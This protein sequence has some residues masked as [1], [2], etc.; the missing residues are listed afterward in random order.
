MFPSFTGSS[1]RPRQVNLSG[2]NT[3]PFAVAQNSRG[4]TPVSGSTNTVLQAQQE[5]L[6]RQQERERV[7][8]ARKI[9]KT[10]RGHSVRQKT[11]REN[12]ERWDMQELEIRA[13]AQQLHQTLPLYRNEEEAL[14]NVHLLL[15]FITSKGDQDLVRLVT[16]VERLQRSQSS[17]SRP[18]SSER[19]RTVRRRLGLLVLTMLENLASTEILSDQTL[20]RLLTFAAHSFQSPHHG[21]GRHSLQYYRSISKLI[22]SPELHLTDRIGSEVVKTVLLDPLTISKTDKALYTAFASEI[23]TIPE[24]HESFNTTQ[25]LFPF[26]DHNLLAS[27]IKGCLTSQTSSQQILGKDSES[28]LWLLAHFIH[29]CRIQMEKEGDAAVLNEDFI[30]VVS[31]LL[32]PM[33]ENL[34]LRLNGFEN[35]TQTP[36]PRYILN[37]ITTLVTQRTITSLSTNTQFSGSASSTIDSSSNSAV[38]L[39]T[40]AL[41]LLRIFPRRSDEIQMWLNMS[42]MSAGI[43]RRS[44]ERQSIPAIKY[45][46]Q[47]IL[48]TDVYLS[49]LQHPQNA[50]KLLGKDKKS[51]S[52]ARNDM[53]GSTS[54]EW[55]I[56]LLFMELYTFVLK[57]TD[58]EEFL[59]SR[60]AKENS[61]QSWTLRS[62]L[63]L[64]EVQQLTLFLKHFAFALYWYARQIIGEE[65]SQQAA[66]L[67]EYF[68][69]ANSKSE[70]KQAVEKIA[71]PENTTIEGL[72]G[73]SLAYM[74]GLTTGLLRMIYERDSRR[75]FLPK[76]FW[77]M[78]K[79]FEMDDFVS[80]VVKE[81][82]RR[83]KI[84]EEDDDDNDN[85]DEYGQAPTELEDDEDDIDEASMVG[86]Q[87]TQ[88]L[89]RIERLRKQ[90]QRNIR[91]K[92]I[93]T[94][95][96]RLEILQNMPFFIPFVTRVEIFHEFIRQDQIKRRNGT[97]DPDLWRFSVV[98]S[99][100]RHGMDGRERAHDYLSKQH[101]K[102]RREKCFDDAFE[103]FFPLGDGLKEPIQITFVDQFDTPEAGI[104]GGGVTKEFLNSVTSEAFKPSVGPNM[105]V[106]NDQHLLYPNP[107]VLDERKEFMRVLRYK[108]GSMEWNEPIRDLLR[109]FEFLGRVIGKC[110]Y[111][112]ILVDIRFAPFFLIKWAL[113]GGSGAATNES[114][115]RANLNDLRDL[116]ESLYQGLLKLKNYPGNVEDFSLDFTVTDVLTQ[117]FSPLAIAPAAP[118]TFGVN[119]TLTRNLRP[120]GG[121]IPVTNENRLVYISYM[122]RHRL[123][124]QPAHQTNAFLRGLGAMINPTWLSMFNQSELQ[125]LLAGDSAEIDVVDLRRNTLYGGVYVIG[126]DGLEHPTVQMFWRV[127]QKFSDENRRK[128]LKYVTSTP[129]GPL[130]GFETL[131]PRFSIRDSGSDQTRLPSTSTCV[132]LLK[133]PIYRDEGILREKLLYAIESGAG[134]DLS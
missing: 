128:L 3:N 78:T 110:L 37:Q 129:R 8:A 30:F 49:T 11:R 76:D 133:L 29:I 14:E 58:D 19:W 109:R 90:Q 48:R 82:E 56:I 16:C 134:F 107:S 104:D 57:V 12:R 87:R 27:S 123:Q 93:D 41:T 34:N 96:P 64:E 45:L 21:S 50:A 86:T 83:S 74:K 32:S 101:A 66:S 95:I 28:V 119:K 116:D 69:T 38:N 115:Y 99:L 84:Q 24:L 77:L 5:R 121:D 124:S 9:Q 85:D 1:R 97:T 111:E 118:P 81:E 131:N 43:N 52:T 62:S 65:E 68:K 114:G 112:G 36:L 89:R 63:D 54:S 98:Q 18:W 130:L 88:Q 91:R 127:L 73:V 46:W 40:F 80:N 92:Q 39:A 55:K 2:R 10:W 20:S 102:I 108:E 70:T 75:K 31:F 60:V 44:G 71:K 67:A 61:P 26:V 25:D 122:A 42:S 23:L 79:Y 59:A 33:A 105:F 113:S 100:A 94:I 51:G 35:T 126:D 53:T 117:P 22:S 4:H 17:S 47:A 125:T 6:A 72:N 132:N 103:Q 15:S 7:Q 13:R 106:E 120:N